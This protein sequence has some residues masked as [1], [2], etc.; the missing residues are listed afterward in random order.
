MAFCI[1][2]KFDCFFF[3]LL[4]TPFKNKSNACKRLIR[5]HVY[6]D[7]DPSPD[8]IEKEEDE[9]ESKADQL[10]T[11]FHQMMNK[12]QYLL[13]MVSSPFQTYTII[14]SFL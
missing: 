13:L 9:L 3:C 11:K 2:Y 10:L 5:Y 14:K 1:Y 7:L 6:H 4:R 8:E 12:Y